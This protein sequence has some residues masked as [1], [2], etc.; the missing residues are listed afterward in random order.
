MLFHTTPFTHTHTSLSLSDIVFV[1]HT[2]LSQTIFHTPYCTHYLCQKPIFH[3]PPFTPIFVTWRHP[4]PFCVAGVAIG[5]MDLRFAW[6]AW[7]LVTWTFVLRARDAAVVLRGRRGTWR[8]GPAF[9]VAGVALGDMD[10]RFAWQAWPF[11][12]WA[13]RA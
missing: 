13:G 5:D 7:H 6:Q 1:T 3:T 4:P 12:D 11:C 9:C 10:L 2:H 8:N